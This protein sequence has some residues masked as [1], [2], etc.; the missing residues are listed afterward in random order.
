MKCAQLKRGMSQRDVF[1]DRGLTFLVFRSCT[2]KLFGFQ[3]SAFLVS[4][5][6]TGSAW[7][8]LGK[9]CFWLFV[10]RQQ[11]TCQLPIPQISVE[12]EALE[13]RH[14]FSFMKIGDKYTCVLENKK[15][16]RLADFF[17][18]F[19]NCA[20]IGLFTFCL[21]TILVTRTILW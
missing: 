2:F 7:N 12:N 19:L 11:E 10:F 3:L 9:S 20:K 18:Y 13:N 17:M 5:V 14:K 15:N 8:V 4:L 1:E 21:S 6:P 16:N